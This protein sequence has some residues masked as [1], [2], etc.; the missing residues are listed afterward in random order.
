[1]AQMPSMWGFYFRVDNADAGAER[2]KANGGR[3]L[4]G[5]V[6]VPGGNRIVQCMDPQGAAF[7]LHQKA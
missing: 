6:D 4:H 2:V 7:S 3:V 1:M 5:P